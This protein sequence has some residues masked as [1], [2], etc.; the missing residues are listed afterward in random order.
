[1]P[2]IRKRTTKDGRDYYEITVSRG[3][4]QS[5]L[6]SR[7][8]IPEGWS[9]RAIDRELAKVAA[10]FERQCKAGEIVSRKEKRQQAALE[11]AEAAKI[12]TPIP[13]MANGSLCPQRP[14]CWPKTAAADT[15]G[16]WIDGFIPLWETENSQ[17]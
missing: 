9:Q 7:W 3:R 12:Q 16:F 13:T 17:K 4:S 1:M 5:R 10:E 6:F 11:A 14:S 2:S 15:K 8:Y